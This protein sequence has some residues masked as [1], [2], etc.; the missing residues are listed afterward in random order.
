MWLQTDP[1]TERLNGLLI[2]NN[3][4]YCYLDQTFIEQINIV[5]T[6]NTFNYSTL[7]NNISASAFCISVLVNAPQWHWS[8]AS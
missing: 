1:L 3:T 8:V 2:Q 4:K 6:S 7:G 5:I